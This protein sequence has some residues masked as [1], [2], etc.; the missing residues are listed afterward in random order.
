MSHFVEQKRSDTVKEVSRRDF[1]VAVG[2]AAALGAAGMQIGQGRASAKPIASDKKVKYGMVINLDR[3]YGCR[4]CM[5]ACKVENNTPSAVFWMYVFRI[6]DG[7]YPN[8]RMQNLPRP[9]MHCDNAPCVK[10]CPVGARY[11][12]D[13]GLVLTDFDRCIGCR[14]CEVACPYGVNYFNWKDPKKNQYYDW[15]S[16]SAQIGTD[17][18]VPPYRNPDHDLLYGQEQRRISGGSHYKGVMGKC[19]FCVHR[20]EKGLLPACVANCPVEALSFGDLNDPESKVSKLLAQKP[21]FRL[22]ED[23]GTEP[24]VHYVGASPLKLEATQLNA[25][26]GRVQ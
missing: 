2:A 24:R 13:D 5:E 11:K 19:T 17:G 18:A 7:H 3:C 14:Y 23:I 8:V 15:D 1:L 22:A 4:A 12:R 10:V 26:V 9:C 21:S 25:I 6:E 16:A 20:V